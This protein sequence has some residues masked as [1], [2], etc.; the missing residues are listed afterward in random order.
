LKKQIT[1]FFAVFCCSFACGQ[2]TIT[3][4]HDQMDYEL[5]SK[6]IQAFNASENY[7]K[8][9]SVFALIQM[10]YEKKR[11][12]NG[13]LRDT[14]ILVDQ[15]LWKEQKVTVYKYLLNQ[16]WSTD[17]PYMVFLLKK[18]GD[19]ESCFTISQYTQS[20]DEVKYMLR[21]KGPGSKY[22]RIYSYEW[23]AITIG[24]ADL[25]NAIGQALDNKLKYTEQNNHFER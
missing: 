16:K 22:T 3:A 1:Y 7:A 21:R 5:Y 18:D 19:F 6:T 17:L 4:S 10:D 20:K 12:P 23:A 24:L 15:F 11:A 13:Y 14:S 25:K 8:A 2:I 9:D